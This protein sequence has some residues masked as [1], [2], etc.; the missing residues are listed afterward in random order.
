MKNNPHLTSNTAIGNKMNLSNHHRASKPKPSTGSI[1][2]LYPVILDG[3]RTIIYTSDKSKESEI[4]EKYASRIDYDRQLLN[5][6]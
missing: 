2:D 3:G 1:K 6:R 4:R 5:G